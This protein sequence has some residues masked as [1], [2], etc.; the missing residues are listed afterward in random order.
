MKILFILQLL[1]LSV[2][3]SAKI[4][5]DVTPVPSKGDSWQVLYKTSNEIVNLE[6]LDVDKSQYT[7]KMTGGNGNFTTVINNFSLKDGVCFRDS[8]EYID[9]EGEQEKKVTMTFTPA[10][11][12]HISKSEM[13]YQ[14]NYQFTLKDGSGQ[15]LD[16]G[17]VSRKYQFIKVEELSTPAGKFTAEKIEINESNRV[18]LLWRNENNALIKHIIKDDKASEQVETVLYSGESR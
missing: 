6:V 3:A 1:V 8:D 13:P 5:G 15:V 7:I 11:R 16:Q 14:E 2:S 4:M 17:N 9:Y 18:R 10:V 12:C